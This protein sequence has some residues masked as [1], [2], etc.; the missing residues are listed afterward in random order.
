[1]FIVQDIEQ[2]NLLIPCWSREVLD[3]GGKCLPAV[4]YVLQFLLWLTSLFLFVPITVYVLYSPPLSKQMIFTSIKIEIERWN[5]HNSS[6]NNRK[7]SDVIFHS[8]IHSWNKFKYAR[9]TY[10]YTKILKEWRNYD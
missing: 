8:I 2:K 6:R 4:L 5:I 9:A 10:I 1:M 7:N 3:V